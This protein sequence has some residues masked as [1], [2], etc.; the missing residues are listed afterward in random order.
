MAKFVLKDADVVVNGVNL[1][2]H[3]ASVEISTSADD[4]NLTAMGAQGVQRQAGLRDESIKIKW[5][6]DFAAA[7]VDAT[8]WPIYS[9]QT[10]V[11]VVVKPFSGAVSATNPSYTGSCYLLDYIPLSGDVGSAADADSTFVVDGVITR[12]VA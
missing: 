5:R 7:K 9:G 1:S 4:V 12:A 2:D 8:L 6:Q 3:V 10:T 11:N